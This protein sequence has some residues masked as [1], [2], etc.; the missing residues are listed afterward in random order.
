V[1]LLSATLE[2]QSAPLSIHALSTPI[3]S[4][5]SL[6]PNGIWG[7]CCPATCLYR[8]LAALSPGTMA[9]PCCPPFRAPARVLR[10]RLAIGLASP[11]HFMHARDRSGATSFANETFFVVC[12]VSVPQTPK[13]SRAQPKG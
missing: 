13:T 3:S 11:W 2:S 9:G 10:S 6:P 5:L 4:A 7:C 1:L 8:R 12:A